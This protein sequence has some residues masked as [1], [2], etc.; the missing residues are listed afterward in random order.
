MGPDR[1]MISALRQ[2]VIHRL[3]RQDVL[4]FKAGDK[5]RIIQRPGHQRGNQPQLFIAEAIETIGIHAVRVSAPISV[6][7]A[8]SGSP[9]QAWT[10]RLS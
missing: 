7:P 3:R 4:R 10:L 6:C 9:T 1:P 8:N 2:R 5:Q